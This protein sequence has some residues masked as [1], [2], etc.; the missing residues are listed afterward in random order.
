M[1]AYRISVNLKLGLIGFAVLIAVASLWYTKDLVDDLK[2]RETAVV[3]LWAA[4]LEQIPKNDWRRDA[5]V[6]ASANKGAPALI[7]LSE[8]PQSGQKLGFRFCLRRIQ[9]LRQPD[10]TWDNLI[11]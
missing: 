4:A 9:C 7:V 6:I 3:Q 11:N 8:N 10:R 5:A 1:K 2:E